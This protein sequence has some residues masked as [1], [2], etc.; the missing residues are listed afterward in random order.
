M[1]TLGNNKN[2]N[3]YPTHPPPPSTMNFRSST[4]H[5]SLNIPI[6][7][8]Y[9][10]SN[11]SST[12]PKSS[13]PVQISMEENTISSS[14]NNISNHAGNNNNVSTPPRKNSGN[15]KD[16]TGSSGKKRRSRKNSK[17]G[18]E[19]DDESP[20]LY[21][22]RSKSLDNNSNNNNNERERSVENN[23]EEEENF[24]EWKR[25]Y[26]KR[27]LLDS[28]SK[29]TRLG[30]K[31]HLSL[32]FFLTWPLVFPKLVESGNPF[33]FSSLPPNASPYKKEK[34]SRRASKGKSVTEENSNANSNQKR[35]E[36]KEKKER[37]M[38][39]EKERTREEMK[40]M[41]R[42]IYFTKV[43]LPNPNARHVSIK[44]V[45]FSLHLPVS[46]DFHFLRSSSGGAKSPFSKSLESVS[47]IYERLHFKSSLG[48]KGIIFRGEEGQ[49]LQLN[50]LNIER[51]KNML[52]I[53][54]DWLLFFRFLVLCAV[55]HD[56]EL[57]NDLFEDYLRNSLSI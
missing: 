42:N 57:Q 4:H 2:S 11:L 18:R 35:R 45:L 20:S 31:K 41:E 48:E 12:P 28:D 39:E 3:Q 53:H 27:A 16:S 43:E 24:N 22:S 36:E 9:F 17:S 46:V 6:P 14:P 25:M 15:F 34:K 37:M 13:P 52:G 56:V 26:G 5:S 51:V 49:H 1:L 40:W 19:S 32:R 50:K 47:E 29:T 54:M 10:S 55:V 30:G 33:L 8:L 21:R 38:L 7:H 44:F 23:E